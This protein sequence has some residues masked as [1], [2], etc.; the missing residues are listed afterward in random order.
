MKKKFKDVTS[1][2]N[3]PAR[4][5]LGGMIR[6]WLVLAGADLGWACSGRFGPGPILVGLVRAHADICRYV[7]S[8][9]AVFF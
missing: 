8:V 3:Q 5:N 1:V 2:V 4:A 6:V 7:L 9:W